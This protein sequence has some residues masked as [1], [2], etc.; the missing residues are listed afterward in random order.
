MNRHLKRALG[1]TLSAAMAVSVLAVGASAI[2]YTAPT[3]GVIANDSVLLGTSS[4]AGT[5][6]LSMLGVNVAASGTSNGIIDNNTDSTEWGSG[7]QH[8]GIFGSDINDN[9]DPLSI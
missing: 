3:T 4:S 9:P 1:F 8:L 6:L 5:T 2:E 7:S